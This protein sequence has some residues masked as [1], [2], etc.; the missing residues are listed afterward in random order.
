MT[1]KE[2]VKVLIG[3]ECE[4]GEQYVELSDYLQVVLELQGEIEA[5]RNACEAYEQQ[6]YR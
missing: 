4:W 6:L 2:K 5:L 3:D 1:D